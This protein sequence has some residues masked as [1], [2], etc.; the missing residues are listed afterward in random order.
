MLALVTIFEHLSNVRRLLNRFHS[1]YVS[2]TF[3][4]KSDEV[5]SS[6]LISTTSTEQQ[7]H[8]ILLGPIVNN[9]LSHNYLK[10]FDDGLHEDLQNQDHFARELDACLLEIRE[11][12]R[13]LFNLKQ[14]QCYYY[15]EYVD[16]IDRKDQLVDKF[17]EYHDEYL[18]NDSNQCLTTTTNELRRQSIG[19]EYN[20]P[21]SNRFDL[22]K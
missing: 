18:I 17:L 12:E 14:R 1:R 8:D 4:T 5:I 13:D 2:P 3:S 10:N 6:D 11:I 22:L 16:F 7:Q 9:I 15:E 20:V 21:V 19:Y